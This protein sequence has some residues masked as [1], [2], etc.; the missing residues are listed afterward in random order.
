ML[1]NAFSSYLHRNSVFHTDDRNISKATLTAHTDKNQAYIFVLP[2]ILTVVLKVIKQ[3]KKN[4]EFVFKGKTQW[5]SSK[6]QNSPV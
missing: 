5:Y 1:Q 2:S 4:K 3:K 6:T